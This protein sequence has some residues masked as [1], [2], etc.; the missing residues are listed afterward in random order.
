MEFSPDER[1]QRREFAGEDDRLFTC[2]LVNC[3]GI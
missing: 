3:V 1:G 2:P